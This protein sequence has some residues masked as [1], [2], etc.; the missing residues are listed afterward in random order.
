[1]TTP[2]T[3]TI[4]ISRQRGSGGSRTARAVADRLGLR[5]VD[6]E[7]LRLAAE[8]LRTSTETA[9]TPPS[10]WW[11]RL[12]EAFASGGADGGYTPSLS[13]AVYEGELFDIEQRLLTEIVDEQPAVIVGRGA[14]QQLRGRP[15]VVAVFLHAPEIHR[16]ARVQ[17][18]YQ[19]R[20]EKAARRAIEMS[21]ADRA[22]FIRSLTDTEWTDARMYDLTVD[23]AA[24]GLERTA[25]LIVQ[26]AR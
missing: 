25:D 16:L 21:D 17:S 9:A 6:R 2:T 4:A 13:E 18:V 7:L 15:G 14:A 3:K 1:M 5:Y 12:G 10:T 26:L 8:Y 24:A 20:D 22:R 11:S 23:T 19:L